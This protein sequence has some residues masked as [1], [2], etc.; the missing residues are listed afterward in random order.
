MFQ[1]T[2]QNKKPLE[3]M[4]EHLLIPTSHWKVV[5]GPIMPPSFSS[6][7]FLSSQPEGGQVCLGYV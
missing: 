2:K 4:K 3:S 7:A 6:K 5:W 1:K